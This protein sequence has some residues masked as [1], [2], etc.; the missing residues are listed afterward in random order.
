MAIYFTTIKAHSTK[1]DALSGRASYFFVD[2]DKANKICD[3]QNTRASS[4]GIKVRYAVRQAQRNDI[5]NS[6]SPR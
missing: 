1:A 6:E 2:E 4:L 5:P 3:T